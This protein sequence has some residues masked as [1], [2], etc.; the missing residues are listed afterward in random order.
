[1]KNK[2]IILATF[3]ALV[4]VAGFYLLNTPKPS[5]ISTDT[6]TE[7]TNG[8]TQEPQLVID[9]ESLD[10]SDPASVVGDFLDSFAS[11]GPPVSSQEALEKA[12]YLLSEGARAGVGEAPTSGD[13]AMLLGVQDIPDEGYEIGEVVYKDNEASG[14]KDGL[15]EINVVL[16]YSGGDTERLFLLS[17]ID[18]FWQIDGIR[19]E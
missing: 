5:T 18:D 9:K 14:I 6:T 8:D 13:L 19:Q 4:F 2:K 3:L 12:A 7:R 17:K 15:A 11:A 10:R 16:K 1:M